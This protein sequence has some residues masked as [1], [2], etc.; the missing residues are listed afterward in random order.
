MALG[1]SFCGAGGKPQGRESPTTPPATPTAGACQPSGTELGVSAKGIAFDN[2]ESG[3]PHNVAIYTDAS[4]SRSLFAGEIITGPKMATHGSPRSRRAP[5]RRPPRPDDRH[6]PRG[7]R[8]AR[9]EVELPGNP[10]P[11]R[12]EPTAP[13]E[14]GRPGVR[15][16]GR[17]A[18]ARRRAA[19]TLALALPMVAIIGVGT[20]VREL[21][22]RGTEGLTGTSTVDRAVLPEPQDGP[23]PP[24]ELPALEG[25]D[26]IALGD[27]AGKVIVLSFWASWCPSCRKDAPVMEAL[28]REHRPL[29]V[30]FLGVNIQDERSDALAFR[31][32]FGI[33][34]PSVFDPAARLAPDYRV[35]GI[36][37]T[38]VIG[39]DQRFRYRLTGRLRPADFRQAVRRV[40]KGEAG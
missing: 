28:W 18:M 22:T 27:Y 17:S 20:A 25:G 34:F 38:F 11:P 1:A 36:P 14:D 39:P 8:Q 30:Q 2:Q 16:L 37:A 4:A 35:F 21:R 3:I 24:F 29:G 5:T 9:R 31:R 13:R 19:W 32:E 26:T 33:T 40:L 15:G 23:A 10:L 6:L 7:M 12:A